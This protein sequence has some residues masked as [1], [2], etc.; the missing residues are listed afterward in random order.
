MRMLTI[1]TALVGVLPYWMRGDLG[2]PIALP[3]QSEENSLI[4]DKDFP[5]RPG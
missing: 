4:Q 2:V 3:E 1:L 5:S